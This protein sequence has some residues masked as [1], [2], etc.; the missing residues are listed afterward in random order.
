MSEPKRC[1]HCGANEEQ[2]QCHDSGCPRG[3][4]P[5]GEGMKKVRKNLKKAFGEAKPQM[6]DIT[7]K[8]IAECE[9]IVEVVRSQL[10]CGTPEVSESWHGI[11]KRLRSAAHLAEQLGFA[12]PESDLGGTA[13]S[14]KS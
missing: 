14:E 3:G 6:E 5:T 9:A 10:L 1:P 2:N 13:A 12:F 4:D 11:A 7:K 8:K